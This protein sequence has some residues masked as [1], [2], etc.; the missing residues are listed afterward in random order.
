MRAPLLAALAAGIELH[1]PGGAMKV[2]TVIDAADN[3]DDD[4]GEGLRDPPRHSLAQSQILASLEAWENELALDEVDSAHRRAANI[5]EE[6]EGADGVHTCSCVTEEDEAR[7]DLTKARWLHIPKA[8]TSFYATLYSY[9]CREKGTIDVDVAPFYRSPS[10]GPCYDFALKE[11]YPAKEYCAA[12][13][14]ESLMTQHQPLGRSPPEHTVA[15]FREPGERLL[16]A[17]LNDHTSGFSQQRRNNLVA[18]CRV[19]HGRGL[20]PACFAAEPGLKG[21]QTRMLLGGRCADDGAADGEPFGGGAL[22]AKQAIAIMER[23]A[24]V[25]LTDRWNEAICLFHKMFGGKVLQAEFKNR[26]QT[27]R[28]KPDLELRD[29]V[30]EPLYA[31]AAARFDQLLKE[32]GADQCYRFQP[33]SASRCVPRT[34]EDAGAE[35]ATIDDGCGGSLSCGECPQWRQPVGVQNLGFSNPPKPL[36]RDDHASGRNELFSKHFSIPLQNVNPSAVAPEH[37]ST[38]SAAEHSCTMEGAGLDEATERRM[39]AVSSYK[40]H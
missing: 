33:A 27:V 25:G 19:P 29:E 1:Q 40:L 3:A 32:H 5:T 15:F 7:R 17:A 30:D 34:C 38:C 10:C 12:N 28:V 37:R 16:S 13:A 6:V 24:F 26:H 8:G 11:R 22:D 35:C 21:C 18:K 31:A 2:E 14:F 39:Y 36:Q 20:D 9:A 4:M 23:L